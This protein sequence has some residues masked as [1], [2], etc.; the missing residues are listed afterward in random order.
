MDIKEIQKKIDEGKVL[1]YLVSNIVEI[2]EVE[3][4]TSDTP[5][6]LLKDEPK[7]KM[8]CVVIKTSTRQTVFLPLSGL[9]E[10]EDLKPGDLVGVS[11][12]SY[13]ILEKLPAEY[14]SRVKAMEVEEKPQEEYTN[15]G[16]LDKQIE[17]L[18]E[19]VVLPITHKDKFEAIGIQPP[20]GCLMFGPPGTG[21]T[22][23]ARACAAQTEATFLKLAGPQLVQ[24]FIG[25]GAKIVR[26]AFQLPID[27][28]IGFEFFWQ[29]Y[30][31]SFFII[32]KNKAAFGKTNQNN[33]R[34]EFLF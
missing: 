26:D 21:K 14:D 32:M 13:L 15:I 10:P 3:N 12:D 11:K 33:L 23:L 24:M 2:L 22:M 25:D 31:G 28:L 18:R 9:I 19:A 5:E 16:G 27:N 1:P 29:S 6:D 7:Q 20:K 17:E 34:H 30:F 4:D 8:K